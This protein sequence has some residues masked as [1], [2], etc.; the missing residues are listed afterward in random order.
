MRHHSEEIMTAQQVCLKRHQHVRQKIVYFLKRGSSYPWTLLAQLNAD[1][2]FSDIIESLIGAIFVDSASSLEDCQR[3]VD[4]IWNNS[5]S[6]THSDRRH[7]NYPPKNRA[8]TLVWVRK[9]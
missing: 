5:V 2:F 4:R 6:T 8:G 9:D 3:F 1:K 7:R